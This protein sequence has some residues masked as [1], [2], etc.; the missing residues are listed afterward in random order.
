MRFF[1]LA[2]DLIETTSFIIVMMENWSRNHQKY[3]DLTDDG[4]MQYA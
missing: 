3:V 2:C 1:L 4:D